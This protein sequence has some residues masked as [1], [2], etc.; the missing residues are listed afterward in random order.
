[1]LLENEL[2]K[3]DEGEGRTWT[4]GEPEPDSDSASDSSIAEGF[5]SRTRW[6]GR[7][8]GAETEVVA[9]SWKNSEPLMAWRSW[10]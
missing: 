8:G 4:Y 6:I 1:L 2:N 5:D 10:K 3:G 9:G 7:V